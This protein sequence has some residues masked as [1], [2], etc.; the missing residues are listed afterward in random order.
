MKTG[1]RSLPTRQLSHAAAARRRLQ[2]WEPG[3]GS[4]TDS[5]TPASPWSAACTPDC[6]CPGASPARSRCPPCARR[7]HARRPVVPNRLP[8]L[9]VLRRRQRV[10]EREG[11]GPVHPARAHASKGRAEGSTAIR[12]A[13]LAAVAATEARTAAVTETA[14]AG[15]EDVG[16]A[17]GHAHAP[18][19]V[20]TSGL[21]GGRAC[22]KARNSYR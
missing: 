18:I 15:T 4:R 9:H 14:G 20:T 7:A 5:R 19:H 21:R 13:H 11:I 8:Q 2:P 22:T 17:R 1:F 12:R 16:V 6:R 3:R 10:D